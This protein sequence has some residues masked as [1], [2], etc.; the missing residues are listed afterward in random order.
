RTGTTPE[1]PWWRT[2]RWWCRPARRSRSG[3]S[4]RP[5]CCSSASAP[6]VLWCCCYAEDAEETAGALTRHHA[7]AGRAT[8]PAVGRQALTTGREVHPRGVQVLERL[9]LRDQCRL[10]LGVEL[11]G[12]GHGRA[13]LPR[14]VQ[15]VGGDVLHG[16][17]ARV[18]R[19]DQ[20]GLSAEDQQVLRRHGQTGVG[21]RGGA[22][23]QSGGPL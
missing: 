1:A 21:Q 10:V 17:A 15:L 16:Q 22:G 3:S 12:E 8:A 19:G 13:E 23:R 2:P 9:A 14:L 4:P 7:G 20:A 11:A 5:C 6:L 18:H